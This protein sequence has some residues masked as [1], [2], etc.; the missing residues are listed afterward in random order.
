MGLGGTHVCIPCAPSAETGEAL[1]TDTPDMDVCIDL[2]RE[3][4]LHGPEYQSPGCRRD[5]AQSRAK[6]HSYG[7]GYLCSGNCLIGK[8]TPAAYVVPVMS[9]LEAGFQ[10]R[11]FHL[12]RQHRDNQDKAGDDSSGT[13]GLISPDQDLCVAQALSLRAI[14]V[15]CNL[16]PSQQVNQDYPINFEMQRL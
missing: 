5:C 13:V 12:T 3:R 14:I 1:F 15:D 2:E 4:K 8:T 10:R 6:L 9:L 7:Q 11:D 16:E